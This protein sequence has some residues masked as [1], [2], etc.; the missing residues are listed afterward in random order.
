MY[1]FLYKYKPGIMVQYIIYG[2]YVLNNIYIEYIFY[3]II[4]LYFYI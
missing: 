1:N 4:C 3:L 2:K